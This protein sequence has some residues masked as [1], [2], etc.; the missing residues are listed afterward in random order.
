VGFELEDQDFLGRGE[1]VSVSW[2]SNVDRDTLQ[3][4]Y[5]DPATVKFKPVGQSL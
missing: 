3:A 1:L 5:E 2:G 4:V